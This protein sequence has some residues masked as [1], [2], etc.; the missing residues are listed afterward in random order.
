MR[1]FLQ[2]DPPPPIFQKCIIFRL[3]FVLILRPDS[4][5]ATEHLSLFVS[6]IFFW[7]LVSPHALPHPSLPIMPKGSKRSRKPSA[8]AA[9]G[10]SSDSTGSN[11]QTAKRP[12]PRRVVWNASRTEFLLDWLDE[13][14]VERQKLFSDSSKDAKDEG[15]RKRVA[16]S[17][18]SEFHKMLAAAVFSVDDDAAVRADFRANPSNYVKSVDNLIIRYVFFYFFPHVFAD[19]L[20]QAAKRISRLQREA[21]PDWGW[22]TI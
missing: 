5:S 3:L 22:T 9:A 11:S 12:K 17:S 10:S 15:R 4:S 13:H 1:H 16:K 14:P 2:N 8:K 7:G 18:K 21:W 6:L 20:F 19:V